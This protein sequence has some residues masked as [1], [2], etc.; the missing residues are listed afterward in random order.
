MKP[1]FART[2]DCDCGA[3]KYLE[4]VSMLMLDAWAAAYSRMAERGVMSAIRWKS[5][6]ACTFLTSVELLA[7]VSLAR[8]LELAETEVLADTP[9]PEEGKFKAGDQVPRMPD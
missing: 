1:P 2:T 8:A 7:S 3:V 5:A 6:S 4:R 9:I